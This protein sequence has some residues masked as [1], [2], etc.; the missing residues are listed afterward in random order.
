ML[1]PPPG[2]TLLAVTALGEIQAM[3]FAPTVWGVQWHPEAT[4]E[5][6]GSWVA[7]EPGPRAEEGLRAVRDAEAELERSWQDL[8]KVLAARLHDGGAM[9]RATLRSDL[10]RLGFADVDRAIAELAELGSPGHEL[11]AILGRSAEPNAALSALLRLA[12]AVDDRDE[13]LTSLTAD[14]GTAMRLLGVLGASTAL[15]DHL[16][17][18]P[19]QWRVL[20][21]PTLGTTRPAAW[22][23][24]A[25]LMEAVGADP[26]P[27]APVATLPEA[28]AVDAL[29]VAYRRLV[30]PLAARDLT[31][32]L[33][34]DD[35][36][37]ELSDLA[38][39]T[40]DAALAVARAHVGEEEAATTRLA[41]IAMGKCGGHELNYVSDVDVIFVHEP[42]GEERRRQRQRRRSPAPPRGSPPR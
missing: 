41:V 4:P 10:L 20:Q 7:D 39:G 8:G 21:D 29:R 13:L 34:I 18:H 11:V 24:R 16:V 32:E 15:A 17:S 27:P 30:L 3:R 2:A 19:D 25:A 9:N 31:H 22:A 28:E 42:A 14:E 5:M 1:A 12:D 33:G 37:A 6:I 26:G 23:I 35:A 36:A 38:A 40:L